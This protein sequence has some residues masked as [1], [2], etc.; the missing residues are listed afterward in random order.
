MKKQITIENALYTVSTPDQLSAIAS[1]SQ[2]KDEYNKL[3]GS[4][5]SKF[6]DK[7]TG[8]KRL[9]EVLPEA[10]AKSPKAP[11]AAKAEAVHVETTPM[12]VE[13]F[14]IQNTPGTDREKTRSFLRANRTF[15][16]AQ[17]ADFLGTST[18]NA[19]TTVQL[20]KTRPGSHYHALVVEKVATATYKVLVAPTKI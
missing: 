13:D 6:S 14:I 17:V 3:T 10:P 5:I 15:T 9:F 1:I 18:S 2:M 7:K 16:V 4:N 8:A 19:N 11:K 20:L 12:M